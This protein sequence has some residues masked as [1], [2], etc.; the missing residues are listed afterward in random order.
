ML[1]D[2]HTCIVQFYGISKILKKF[3]RNIEIVSGQSADSILCFGP[4]ASTLSNFVNRIY[5]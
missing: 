4:S 2:F 5:I 1:F 3:G